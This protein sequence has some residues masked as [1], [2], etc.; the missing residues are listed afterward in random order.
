MCLRYTL[1]A[2]KHN[3]HSPFTPAQTTL[4]ILATL[5]GLVWIIVA[6]R[7]VFARTSP[8]P[9]PL[10]TAPA[11]V[12]PVVPT[13][14]ATLLL[15]SATPALLPLGC[16]ATAGPAVEGV[17]QAVDANAVTVQ[18]G[19]ETLVFRLEGIQLPNSP[20]M[21]QQALRALQ[22][23]N[24][25]QPV[26]VVFEDT[27]RAS[28]YLLRGGLLVNLDLVQRGLALWNGVLPG[29]ACV[30]LLQQAQAQAQ[31]AK[32]GLWLPT[33]VATWTFVPFVTLDPTL[34]PCTCQP[35]PRCDDFTAQTQAQACYNWC[36]DYNTLLD[37][38][39]DGI[40]CEEL[41]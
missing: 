10:A 22:E 37:N 31:A 17:L 29:G 21:L 30:P 34:Q 19:A 20:E 13:G 24:A 7:F 14:T 33:P 35:R 6:A 12:V 9:P 1:P 41:P 2:M 16:G 11:A 27:G 32:I 15:P 39:R 38:D 36:N 28:G 8:V 4:L 5:L 3:R 40:A 23:D 25:G 26:Q 18:A